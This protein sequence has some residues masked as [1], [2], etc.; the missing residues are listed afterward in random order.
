MMIIVIINRD[1]D[2]VDYVQDENGDDD[3]EDGKLIQ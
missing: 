1:N 2:S 3:F